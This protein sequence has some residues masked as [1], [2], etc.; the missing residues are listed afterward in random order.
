MHTCISSHGLERSWRSCP[1]RV[2]ADNKNTPSTHHP[3]RRNV[4]GWIKKTTGHIR[5]NLTQKWWTQKK[6]KK[7][8]FCASCSSSIV[9]HFSYV[10]S[11]FPC[12]LELSKSIFFVCRAT[13]GVTVSTCAFPACHQCYCAGS[14]LAWG[15]NLRAAVCGIFWSS[16][17]GFFFR[18]LRFPSLLHPANK[19]KLK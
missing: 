5:K 2:N 1:R 4:T 16:S 3:R 11:S 17:S 18:V 19:M 12:V 9:F 6:K 13:R 15:L 14:S 8:S 10:P 7:M